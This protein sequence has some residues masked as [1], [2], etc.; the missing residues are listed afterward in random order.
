M[1]T[2]RLALLLC[3]LVV[4]SA[5]LRLDSLMAQEE[6]NVHFRWA[7]GAL[8]G[9]EDPPKL[10]AITQDTTLNTGDRL[11]MLVE[12]KKQCFV[13]VIHHGPQGEVHWLFPANE[14]QL[15]TDY[16]TAKRYDVPPGDTW[17]KLDDQVGRET[18]YILA[19]AERLTDLETLLTTYANAPRSEQPQIGTN[20]VAEI[21]EMRKR[22]RQFA[23]LAERPV[24]IAGNLRGADIGDLAVEITAQNF[25]SKT[26]TI[27]HR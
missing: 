24:P 17:F 9:G 6:A 26:F 21:R 11:K 19:A 22:F 27:E 15:A 3:T 5:T 25:Y 7:F 4:C 10:I 18:F 8:V 23:T 1:K 12:L 20:I 16:Q 14:Q 13:Y 2:R